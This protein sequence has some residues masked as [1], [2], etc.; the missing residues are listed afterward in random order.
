MHQLSPEKHNHTVFN[1]QNHSYLTE[2]LFSINH[3]IT[4]PTLIRFLISSMNSLV[5]ISSWTP[6]PQFFIQ[7][8]STWN[9]IVGL[10]YRTVLYITLDKKTLTNNASNKSTN[11]IKNGKITYNEGK[12][13]YMG[14]FFKHFFLDGCYSEFR[15]EIS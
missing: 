6:D 5:P 13:C 11:K 7:A 1:I 3:N 12:F 14:I 9:K 2:K 4:Q 8:S 10:Y 15:T